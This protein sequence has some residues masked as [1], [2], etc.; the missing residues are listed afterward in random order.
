MF[1][2]DS[3][4][5]I[6]WIDSSGTT[7]GLDFA[8][9]AQVNYSQ[10]IYNHNDSLGVV[11]FYN[12][13]KYD[14][15]NFN[16]ILSINL[17]IEK[18]FTYNN[19][20]FVVYDS[21]KNVTNGS[22]I[23]NVKIR[24]LLN[25]STLGYQLFYTDDSNTYS[26]YFSP[27]VSAIKVQGSSIYIGGNFRNVN[28]KLHPTSVHY[29]GI[30]MESLGKCA[31]A[32]VES[33]QY[34][35]ALCSYVDTSS[36]GKYIY[37]GGDFIFADNQLSPF[38]AKWDGTTWSC[39]GDG[40]DNMVRALTSYNGDIYAS[41]EFQNSGISPTKHVAILLGNTWAP[42]ANGANGI[43]NRMLV[44]SGKLY[45]AGILCK[46]EVFTLLMLLRMMAPISYPYSPTIS[47]KKFTTWYC[48]E[49][50]HLFSEYRRTF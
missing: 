41:G 19:S 12:L 43:V 10:N 48:I 18:A 8:T 30:S 4:R 39:P 33:G 21:T 14:G 6:A 15:V 32:Y 20:V 37:V 23:R 22:D 36:A 27:E 26:T 29:N 44:K 11:G 9:A 31:K 49:R 47:M 7:G 16:S 25:D 38:I 24:K 28:N 13:F 50:H 42:L 1:N 40:F 2:G 45:L 34:A 5:S 35:L 17:K 46:L 3:V